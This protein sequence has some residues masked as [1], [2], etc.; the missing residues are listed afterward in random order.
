MKC[1]ICDEEIDVVGHWDSGHNAQ[2]VN[3]GRCCTRCN[4]EEVL[5]RR[6]REHWPSLSEA[7]AKEFSRQIYSKL[8]EADNES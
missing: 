2:P 4:T 6:L 8:V 7:E 1:S 3:D 5:P